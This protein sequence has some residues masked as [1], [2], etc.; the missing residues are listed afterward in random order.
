MCFFLMIT[1]ENISLG[2]KQ[3]K[4]KRVLKLVRISSETRFLKTVSFYNFEELE[5]ELL[6]NVKKSLSFRNARDL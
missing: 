6:L 2:E 3:A 5:A 1:K 4:I